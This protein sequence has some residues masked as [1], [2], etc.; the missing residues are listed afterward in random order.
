MLP[1]LS[2]FTATRRHLAAPMLS[3][4]LLALPLTSAMAQQH[5]MPQ[6]PPQ[7]HINAS[8]SV[9][10]TPDRARISLGV[11]TEAK[12]AQEASQLNSAAQ[13]RI[14]DALRAAGIPQASIRT[15]GFNVSPKQE[16]I[17][18]TRTYRIDGYRVSNIVVVVVEPVAKTGQVIDAALG[19]GANRVAG[20]NFEIKDPTPAREQAMKEAVE[21]AR[22]EADI[23][24]AAAGGTIV[25][26]LEIIVN[27]FE[28]SPPRPMME[29][30]RASDQSETPIS[31]GTQ[32]V[33]VN[34]STRWQYAP[35]Q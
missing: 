19:A 17:P 26:L 30:M 16:Y 11:E 23:V 3:A 9:Q 10:V 12:T 28:P 32:P 35:R 8:G 34:I 6:P 2:V 22:R 27:S 15:T 29:M 1:I 4:V 25:G 13:T 20:L 31:E 5:T 24:A 33:V 7:I 14:I 18:E 21:R